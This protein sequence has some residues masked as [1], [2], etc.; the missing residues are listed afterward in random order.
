[1]PRKPVA[2]KTT[3]A[4]SG[5][6]FIQAH[7]ANDNTI[8]TGSQEKYLVTVSPEQW[9]W[10]GWNGGLLDI[11]PATREDSTEVDPR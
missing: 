10:T 6:A 8:G 4:G 5:T 1:M 9:L 3:L 2:S 7:L 11:A